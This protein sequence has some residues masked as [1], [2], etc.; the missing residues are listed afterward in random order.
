MTLV[1]GLYA[2]FADK[3]N[4][5]GEDDNGVGSSQLSTCQV[6]RSLLHT[7]LR[8]HQTPQTTVALRCLSTFLQFFAFLAS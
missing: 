1:A 8:A 7:L 4:D 2:P 5:G 3:C 6:I